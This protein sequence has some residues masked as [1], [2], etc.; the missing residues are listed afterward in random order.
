MNDDQ[1]EDLVHQAHQIFGKT[2]IYEVMDLDR[3]AAIV[4][5]AESYGPYDPQQLEKY[6]SILDQLKE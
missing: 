6:F 4:V 2:S 5:L 1:I 3:E